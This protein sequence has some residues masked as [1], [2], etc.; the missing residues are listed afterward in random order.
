MGG[1][2]DSIVYSLRV[3]VW[4]GRRGR[5]RRRKRM[6]RKRRRKRRGEEEAKRSRAVPQS[7]GPV[8]VCGGRAHDA[9]A[10]PPDTERDPKQQE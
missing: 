10:R 6:R 9:A 8:P 3:G 7:G 5:K 2:V 1:G 4:S